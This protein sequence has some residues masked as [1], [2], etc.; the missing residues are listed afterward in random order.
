M[1]TCKCGKAFD[2]N[3]VHYRAYD[4]KK[5]YEELSFCSKE[6]LK[7]W[8]TGKQIGMWIAV[9]LGVILA[10]IALV[11]GYIF[12]TALVAL[13]VPYTLR[14]IGS[15]LGQLFSGGVSGEILSIAVFLIATVT[16]VYPAYKFIQELK[17]YKRLKVEYNL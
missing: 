17:Q 9:G 15:M 3:E 8:V 16:I 11:Q 13:V 14:Q 5:S 7:E 10:I 12:Y 2:E 6:C 4:L 1:T